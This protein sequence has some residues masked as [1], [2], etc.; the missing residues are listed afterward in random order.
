MIEV[1]EL[2]EPAE[3]FAKLLAGNP[4]RF[5]I[6]AEVE[7]ATDD[8]IFGRI[9]FWLF[10]VA[11]GDW[12]DSADLK[13]CV[14]WLRDFAEEPRDRYDARLTGL[15]NEAIFDLIYTPVMDGR[16]GIADPDE[17]PIPRAYSRF[18]ITHLGMS[19]FDRYVLL[20]VKEADG[21]ERCLWRGGGDEVIRDC[22]LWPNE[23]ERV[24]SD[25]CDQFA[26]LTGSCGPTS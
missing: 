7:P 4:A 8:W 23:M 14:R 22:W 19:S 25:F 18:H 16:R 2:P 13:G 26:R 15:S 5:A 12:T 3:A 1:S 24:A 21:R 6:E 11:V 10:G 20:L 9:R 17:Q